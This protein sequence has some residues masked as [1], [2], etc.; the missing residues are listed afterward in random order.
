MP[1][2]VPVATVGIDNSANAALLAVRILAISDPEL[3][4]KLHDYFGELRDAVDKMNL[5]VSRES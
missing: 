1:A 4:K 3:T 5:D 2:G